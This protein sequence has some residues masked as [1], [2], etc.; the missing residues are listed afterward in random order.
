MGPLS[1]VFSDRR[2][3]AMGAAVFAAMCVP[4]LALSGFVFFEPRL[5][6]IVHPGEEGK[7]A[8]IAALSALSGIVMPMNLYRAVALRAPGRRLG[9]GAAGSAVGAAAGACG[10]GPVG[11]AM[12]SAFGG[13][14]ASVAAFM[15][16]HEMP[17]RLASIA[18]LCAAYW[19]TARSI[20]AECR[21]GAGSGDGGAGRIRGS[22]GGGRAGQGV[23]TGGASPGARAASLDGGGAGGGASPGREGR[24][25]RAGQGLQT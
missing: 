7:L 17:I 12:F 25:G 19:A 11:L 2:Y 8:A 20:R 3:A 5:A 24:R 18:V 10:C 16:N 23:G 14:G 1:I 6:W 4:L 22:A 21:V 9:G 15:A 13:A